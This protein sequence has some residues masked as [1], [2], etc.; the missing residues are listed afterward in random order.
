MLLFEVPSCLEAGAPGVSSEITRYSWPQRFGAA[1]QPVIPDASGV[2]ASAAPVPHSA[3][4]GTG[5]PGAQLLPSK[6]SSLWQ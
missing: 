1:V 5:L 4:A 3:T 6:R 2:Y